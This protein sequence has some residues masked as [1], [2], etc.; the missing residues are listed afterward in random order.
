MH[1]NSDQDQ[2]SS[3]IEDTSMTIEFLRARLLS[4]RSVSKSARQR[5]DELVERVAELEEQ[6]RVVSLQRKKAEKAVVDVVAILETHGVNDISVSYYSSS[7]Q[8]LTPQVQKLRGGDPKKS[9]GSANSIE[10]DGELEEFSSPELEPSSATGRRLPW[11]GRRDRPSH[12]SEKFKDSPIRRRS[13]FACVGSSSKQQL[14]KSCRQIKRRNQRSGP[15]TELDDD[16]SLKTYSHN[17]GGE[18]DTRMEISR[19]D[20]EPQKENTSL[21]SAVSNEL[22][23]DFG[24]EGDMERALEHQALLIGQYKEMEKEQREWE[25]KYREN[26]SSTVESCDPG[27]NSDITEEINSGSPS[28]HGRVAQPQDPK[29]ELE[30]HSTCNDSSQTHVPDG[31]TETLPGDQKTHIQVQELPTSSP[32]HNPMEPISASLASDGPVKHQNLEKNSP[33]ESETSGKQVESHAMAPH[34]TSDQVG[35]L[36]D[37]LQQ[38]KLLLQKEITWL[39]H[40]RLGIAVKAIEP[41]FHQPGPTCKVDIPGGCSGL[42]RLPTDMTLQASNSNLPFWGSSSGNGALL[43]AE[44]RCPNARYTESMPAGLPVGDRFF[45][46]QFFNSASRA[47]PEIPEIPRFDP[48]LPHMF[49]SYPQ[50][51]PS[52]PDLLQW[53]LPSNGGYFPRLNSNT[54]SAG[55][56][57]D[58]FI[59]ND[60]TSK[61]KMM[62]R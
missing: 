42:F 28:S 57:S 31:P 48:V 10:R 62:Y 24:A 50:H 4:E 46:N 6:L 16:S 37:R 39:P 34:Q 30:L 1:K 12:S 35:S 14:G 43:T 27:N 17:N 2:R 5:A 52:Y 41:S 33:L 61:G 29:S 7:D 13:G 44:D 23:D 22:R 18:S 15:S 47:V 21:D 54:A 11:K 8:D 9:E 45:A 53:R 36:L 59:F 25:E 58:I 40:D 49:T 3:G 56:P 38:A 55:P 60:N 51:H 19:V 32:L 20:S 26:N